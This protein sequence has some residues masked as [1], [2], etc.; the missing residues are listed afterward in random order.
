MSVWTAEEKQSFRTSNPCTMPV[1]QTNHNRPHA[2]LKPYF[3]CLYNADHEEY[4]GM[5]T[6][7]AMD[8]DGTDPKI[9]AVLPATE[10]GN[11][12][13]EMHVSTHMDYYYGRAQHRG[14]ATWGKGGALCYNA[15][16][17]DIDAHTEPGGDGEAVIDAVCYALP[18]EGVSVPNVIEMS[19]R[20]YHL[21]RYID[22]VAAALGWMVEAVSVFFAQTVQMLLT[23]SGAKGY[24]ADIGYARRIAGL[25]RIPGTYNTAAHAYAGYRTL[26][27]GRMDLLKAYD[28]IPPSG[29]RGAIHT[30]FPA[31]KEVSADMASIG[32]KRMDALLCLNAIRPIQVSQR[33][34]YC[35]HFFSAAQFAGKSNQDALDLVKSE[36]RTFSVPLSECEV[37]RYLFT[38]ARKHYKFTTKRV[39]SDLDITP[40]ECLAI[41]LR[42]G[43]GR[44]DTNRAR[45]ARTADRRQKRDRAVMRL[46]LLGLT[47]T[48]IAKKVGIAYNSVRT[49]IRK[50]DDRLLSIFSK[51]ELR[52]IRRQRIRKVISAM[53]AAFQN[54][55][56]TYIMLIPDTPQQGRNSRLQ[57]GQIRRESPQQSRGFSLTVEGTPVGFSTRGSPPLDGEEKEGES[58]DLLDR[59][60]TDLAFGMTRAELDAVMEP[61]LYIGRSKEVERLL[62]DAQSA[63]G[64]I[65]L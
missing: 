11:W 4:K 37:E 53:K 61:S 36:N 49:V 34:M 25:T 8:V 64:T 12:A 20:G 39:I 27:K 35:L 40:S 3:D 58:C 44:R 60:A 55:K 1:H 19:G 32:K 52:R 30:A 2:N 10:V 5:V 9:I 21:V 22:Q 51:K 7:A 57:Q 45:N 54:M 15:V 29:Q 59:L 56:R 65:S 23:D 33:D 47:P 24:Q 26:H 14:N 38:A 28:S 18:E 42:A 6:I 63:D 50:Y 46:H 13:S 41:G 43:S 17:V 16:Y 48:A 62:A 31:V